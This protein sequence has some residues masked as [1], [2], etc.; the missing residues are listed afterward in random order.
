MHAAKNFLDILSYF[1]YKYEEK[2]QQ[3]Y[4]DGITLYENYIRYLGAV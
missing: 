4:Q 3:L 2:A 1:K